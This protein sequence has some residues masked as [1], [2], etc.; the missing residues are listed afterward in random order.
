MPNTAKPLS[1]K[2]LLAMPASSYMN[3]AQLRF[4]RDLLSKQRQDLL[5]N[6]TMTIDH[7][8]DGEAEADPNDRATIEEENS[9]EL[10]IRDRERKMLPRV[11]A[12]LKRIDDGRYGFCE[13]TGEPIG[14]RRLLARPT[15]V[16]SIEAQE[17]HESRQRIQGK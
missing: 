4:F 14:L 6:A 11:D 3:A 16:Y 13:D 7:L 12:A 5:D 17:R 1:E 15:T 10:R 8:R 2:A 9:L